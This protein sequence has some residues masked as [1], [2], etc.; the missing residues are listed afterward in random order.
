MIDGDLP[1]NRKLKGPIPVLL[2]F[3]DDEYIIT[4]ENFYNYSARE[5]LDEAVSTFFQNLSDSYDSLLEEENNLGEH[6][7]AELEYFRSI[8]TE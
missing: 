3:A 7:Q 6:L 4:E 5:T 2:D 1:G 8:I